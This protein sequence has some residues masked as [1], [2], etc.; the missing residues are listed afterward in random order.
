[1]TP[2]IIKAAVPDAKVISALPTTDGPSLIL[3][4]NRVKCFVPRKLLYL[5]LLIPLM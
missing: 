4:S 5:T 2:K 3:L 1:M